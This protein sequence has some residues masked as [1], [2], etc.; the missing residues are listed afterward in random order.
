[1]HRCS[2][3]QSPGPGSSCA[4]SQPPGN[5][6]HP[7]S[8]PLLP[9]CHVERQPGYH[10]AAT[11]TE[12]V[13]SWS[14]GWRA[15]S[16]PGALRSPTSC[17]RRTTSSASNSVRGGRGSRAVSIGYLGRALRRRRACRSSPE[18]G[19]GSWLGMERWLP[20]APRWEL[21]RAP[22]GGVGI[23]G[24]VLPADA[25]NDPT[26]NPTSSATTCNVLGPRGTAKWRD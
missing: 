20:L 23:V 21:A 1:M 3:D 4:K 9:A 26:S 16:I 13:G 22:S 7:G 11:G 2:L 14:S 6:K 15:G 18:S 5:A 12:A 8:L 25:E 10:G 19:P 24:A 17:M